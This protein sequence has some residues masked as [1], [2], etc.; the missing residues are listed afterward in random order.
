MLDQFRALSGGIAAKLLLAFLVLTFA[1][2]GIGDMV[3]HPGS[4]ITVATVGDEDISARE[5]DHALRQTVEQLQQSLGGQYSP[6][7][8]KELQVPRHVAR[9]LVDQ[10]LIQLESRSIG[11][12]PSDADVA[13]RIRS[14][15]AFQNEQGKFDKARFEAI[16]QNQ[17]IT[18]K[19]YV[20]QLR[21]DMASALL[22]DTLSAAVPDFDEAA[23]TLYAA[24]EQ[25]RTATFYHLRPS[26]I[27]DVPNPTEAEANA[28]YQ[29]HQAAFTVPEYRRVSY[30]T[31]SAASLPGKPETVP[32]EELKRMYAD[33]ISEFH[34]PERREVEQLL[35]D[36]RDKAEKAE[37]LLKSGK[38]AEQAARE[39]PVLNKGGLSLGKVDKNGIIDAAADKVFALKP[40]QFT[41][42]IKSPF[43]WHVFIVS[44]IDPPS[45]TPFSEVRPQIEKE[46]LQ[47]DAD[48][49]LNQFANRLQDALAGGATLAE[50]AH[51]LGLALKTAGPF[52]RQGVAQAGGEAGGIP[53]LDKFIDTA[54]STDE[55]SQSSLMTARKGVYYLLQDDGITPS[56]VKPAAEVMAQITAGW[57][58]Q[59]REKKLAA[60][61]QN[62]AAQ[63]A[64][65][66]TRAAA[67]AAYHLTPEEATIK[68]SSQ[69]AG[70]LP[71]PPPLIA[72]V[73]ARKADEATPAFPLQDG[74]WALAVAG[75]T[76]PAP[77]P[78]GQA[79]GAIRQKLKTT[80]ES[81]LMDQYADYLARKYPVSINTSALQRLQP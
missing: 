20:G 11:L 41:A 46:A 60:L 58:Q 22:L 3:R 16:L 56:H 80:V 25:R 15:P 66:A 69:T 62:I 31:F 72:S 7:L 68:R 1:V 43:G 44:A 52:D 17:G 13:R 35:Y 28:Y 6:G 61:A 2:W 76:I 39:I 50:A 53:D 36:S 9:Q 63:F 5:F 74:S 23:R 18:E 8:L 75:Q 10:R 65:P 14:N 32:V 49:A 40:G 34:R 30:V 79:L 12:V 26:L 33:Q 29:A 24:Q 81:E 54:F 67:V 42:P 77:P 64:S 55:K 38:N 37:A 48:D 59:E 57:Q 73:F 4:N 51:D 70:D 27:T 47:R 19:I 78:D 45:V 21:R 71:L